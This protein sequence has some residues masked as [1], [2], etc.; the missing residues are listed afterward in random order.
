MGKKINKKGVSSTYCSIFLLTRA[1]GLS[2]LLNMQSLNAYELLSEL[3]P[4]QLPA[5]IAC[6]N[7]SSLSKSKSSQKKEFSAQCEKFLRVILSY[8]HQIPNWGLL[9]HQRM[10]QLQTVT[11]SSQIF[12]W[13]EALEY[14]ILKCV[15]L[16]FPKRFI[17]LNFITTEIPKKRNQKIWFW[18]N[19]RNHL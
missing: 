19:W 6:S 5:S 16:H 3:E 10:I 18:W 17:F 2:S 13:C 12:S 15:F 8:F 11:L 7:V 4:I 9:F 14:Y 1:V